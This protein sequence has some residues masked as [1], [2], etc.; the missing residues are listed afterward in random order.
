MFK[1]NH[2]FDR[3]T[4]G[5]Y[6]LTELNGSLSPIW[7][8]Q[9]TE[10]KSCDRQPDGTLR[11]TSDHP[12]GFEWCVNAPAVDRDGTVY[13][14]SEDGNIY[15][16]TTGQIRDRFFLDKSVG[17]AYTPLS[18]DHAGRIYV[19]NNGHMKVVGGY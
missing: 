8:F 10:T 14:N 15:A 12:S 5:P 18:I 1:D 3:P 19:L 11:C 7:Q 6:Y 4:P 2:Y 13:A 9:N 17:A 16:I